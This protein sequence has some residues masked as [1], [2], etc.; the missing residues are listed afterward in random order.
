MTA[1]DVMPLPDDISVVI[2]E[3]ASG[4]EAVAK[5][6]INTQV[7]ADQSE[8]VPGWIGRDADAYTDSVKK[9]GEHARALGGG[10]SPA[11]TALR[12]WGAVLRAMISTTV[13]NLWQ[14]YDEA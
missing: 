12:D 2:E 11:I 9:L 6:V 1:Q 3:V 4:W 8:G 7:A 14:R 13:P 10:F 5:G